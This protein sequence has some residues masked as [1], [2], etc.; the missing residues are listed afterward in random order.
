MPHPQI[1]TQKHTDIHTNISTLKTAIGLLSIV[2]KKL[3]EIQ[4][5]YESHGS[6]PLC[7]SVIVLKACLESLPQAS[8]DDTSPIY[9]AKERS[10]AS[11][12]PIP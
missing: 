8:G 1:Y 11:S 7:P 6:L 3:N 10:P 5:T 2:T 4:Y 9:L 12:L